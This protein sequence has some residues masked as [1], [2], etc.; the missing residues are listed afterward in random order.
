MLKDKETWDT[1][2]AAAE[3]VLKHPEL[4]ENM[5]YDHI[6]F[7]A[8]LIEVGAMTYP[9]LLEGNF[10]EYHVNSSFCENSGCEFESQAWA[11][12][13]ASIDAVQLFK[14]EFQWP[15]A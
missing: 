7:L 3:A 13:D 1:A 12:L 8:Q 4:N 9:E 6:W 2:L 10:C 11:Y 5:T 14:G 15:S